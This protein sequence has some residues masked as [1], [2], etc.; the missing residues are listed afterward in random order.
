MFPRLSL[1]L[2]YIVYYIFVVDLVS[3]LVASTLVD[4]FVGFFS[5]IDACKIYA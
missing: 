3:L 1:P 4:V 2:E 5:I